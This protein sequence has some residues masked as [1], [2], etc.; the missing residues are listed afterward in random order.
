MYAG[1]RIGIHFIAYYN[2]HT[3]TLFRHSDIIA[4]DKKVCFYRQLFADPIKP[5]RT[6]TN[7]V[8]SLGGIIKVACGPKL[9]FNVFSPH[10]MVRGAVA[11]FWPT[12]H[13]TWSPVSEGMVNCYL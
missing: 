6:I 9:P 5:C 1:T 7:P 4:I 11:I 2:S 8:G 3:Q 13:T 10:G 12:V